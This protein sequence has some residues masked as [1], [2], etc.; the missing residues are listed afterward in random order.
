MDEFESKIIESSKRISGYIGS[1]D[2]PKKI[3]KKFGFIDGVWA[4]TMVPF[5]TIQ[6]ILE[7][8]MEVLNTTSTIS[9]YWFVSVILYR[10]P[11][12]NIPDPKGGYLANLGLL[13]LTPFITKQDVTKA[14]RDIRKNYNPDKQR[15]NPILKELHTEIIWKANEAY[16]R[17]IDPDYFL[18]ENIPRM[19]VLENMNEIMHL[20]A[21]FEYSDHIYKQEK[22]RKLM[23]QR[24]EEMT[25]EE[26]QRRDFDIYVIEK[27]IQINEFYNKFFG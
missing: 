4:L 12:G 25:D 15:N 2:V 17:L 11:F 23:L 22:E 13:G 8:V 3:I 16:N 19:W 1:P 14:Y 6:K 26:K 20:D 7:I 27:L 18:S 9:L 5:N 21:I 10:L 24:E